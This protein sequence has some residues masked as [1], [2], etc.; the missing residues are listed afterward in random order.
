MGNRNLSPRQFK[1]NSEIEVPWTPEEEAEIGGYD[2]GSYTK[3]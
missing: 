2:D 1:F 3:K